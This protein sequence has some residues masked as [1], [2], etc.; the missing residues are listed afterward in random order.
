MSNLIHA[1]QA[2]FVLAWALPLIMFWRQAVSKANDKCDQLAAAMWFASLSIIAFPLKWLL[3]G[4]PVSHM[5]A[6]DLT[7]WC[8]LYVAGSVAGPRLT[9]AVYRNCNGNR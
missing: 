3:L 8:V 4:A 6:T 9:W 1:L 2:L 5:T 7:L